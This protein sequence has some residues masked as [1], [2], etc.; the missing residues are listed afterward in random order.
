LRAL[1]P[2][3]G[4]AGAGELGSALQIEHPELLTQFPMWLWLKTKLWRLPPPADLDVVV[5]AAPDGHAG[6]RQI[7][8]QRHNCTQLLLELRCELLLALSLLAERLSFVHQRCGIFTSPL[9]AS[10]FF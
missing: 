9:A 7:G 5:F 10:H 8:N 3:D 4:E 1:I 2:I 6:V